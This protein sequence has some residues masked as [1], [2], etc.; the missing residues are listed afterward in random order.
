M[1][2]SA[3]LYFFTASLLFLAAAGCSEYFAIA[4]A[5]EKQLNNRETE[6]SKAAESYFW[7]NFHEG[8]YDSIPKIKYL[9]TAAYLEN[10]S[11]SI[12][13]AHIAFTNMWELAERK[14]AVDPNNPAIIYNAT[15]AKKFFDESY[16]LNSDDAR[17]LGF[18]GA[19]QM[20]EGSI[21]GDEEEIRRGYYTLKHS[22]SDFPEFNDFTMGYMLT[23]LDK[24]NDKFSEG[25]EYFWDNVDE[26]TETSIN[27]KSPDYKRFMKLETTKGSKRVCWN[28]VIAPH[29]FE[30]FFM[31]FGDALVKAGKWKTAVIIYNNAKYSKTYNEWKYKDYLEDRITN[32]EQNVKNFNDPTQ[33][34]DKKMIMFKSSFSCMSCH[35]N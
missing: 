23:Q 31:A 18:L 2:K 14:R 9:L 15:I 11:N 8:N 6:L 22:V 28:G 17:I 29:N 19:A 25:L 10:P 30:G 3:C 4:F 12:L 5:P 27:R 13:A 7:A 21:N 20:T 35:R 33:T 1:I 34:D 32:A 26:C 24:S 16:T